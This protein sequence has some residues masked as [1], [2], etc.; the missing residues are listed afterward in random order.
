[1]RLTQVHANYWHARKAPA[2]ESRLAGPKRIR[3]SIHACINAHSIAGPLHRIEAGNM[4]AILRLA[5]KRGEAEMLATLTRMQMCDLN[6]AMGRRE[7][8]ARKWI[9]RIN[10]TKGQA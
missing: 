9:A 10:R 8:Y 6:E 2:F 7:S 3:P 4:L 1:M 5:R